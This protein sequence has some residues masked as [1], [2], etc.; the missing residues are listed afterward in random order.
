[1]HGYLPANPEMRS[2]FFLVGP[3]VP[4]SNSL[5]EIDMRQIAPTLAQILGV[6]LPDAELKPLNIHSP[7]TIHGG[8]I[9]L[10]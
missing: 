1:M 10:H 3:S 6:N 8:G 9:I 7:Q 4:H 2:S 5:G